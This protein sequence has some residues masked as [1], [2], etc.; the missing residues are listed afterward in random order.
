[1]WEKETTYAIKKEGGVRARSVHK[2]REEAEAALTKGYFLEVRPGERTR[3]QTFCQVAPFCE[4]FKKYK[5]EHG[6][7][8]D[9]GA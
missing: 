8:S 2:T 3:C 1:M 6:N 7:V 9:A 4:Q 5:E